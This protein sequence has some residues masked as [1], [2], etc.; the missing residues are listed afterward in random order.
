[1][2]RTAT[3]RMTVEVSYDLEDSSPRLIK[4]LKN[5]LSDS[6]TRLAGEGGMTGDLPATVNDWK[7]DVDGIY[8]SHPPQ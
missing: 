8:S 6:I 1:M 3:L 2:S 5:N 4:D 7:V